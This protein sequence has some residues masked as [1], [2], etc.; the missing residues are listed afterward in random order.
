M[1]F[2]KTIEKLQREIEGMNRRLRGKEDLSLSSW[3]LR[4]IRLSE[5][6][7]AQKFRKAVEDV[8]DELNDK[9]LIHLSEKK[10]QEYMGGW[11]EVLEEIKTKLED[12]E[13]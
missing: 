8:I 2:K 11:L 13:I 7:I 10:S 3:R 1:I 6:T 12:V 4:N 5:L 9:H